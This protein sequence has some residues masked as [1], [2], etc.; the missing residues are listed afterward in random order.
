MNNP[1]KLDL[2][3][4]RAKRAG[5]LGVD[6]LELPGVDVCHDLNL[7]PYPF[8]D[9]QFDEIWLDQVLEHLGDPLRVM[10]EVYRI[11]GNGA[12]VTVGVPYFRSRY[13]VIDPTHRNFF[14]VD[15]FSYFDPRHPFQ[16]KYR[17]SSARFRVDRIEFDRE[18]KQGRPGLLHRM[19]I[20][21][22]ES[23]PESYE[24]RLS[25]LLPLN[26]LTFYLTAIK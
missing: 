16:E 13:A 14:G 10:E 8:A 2:G 25:H 15:W 12:H 20:R 6:S 19:L 4:G 17:Y 21:L 9:S 3:C 7:F 22:A 26:S 11:C 18:F 5:F 23:R 24:L 1:A